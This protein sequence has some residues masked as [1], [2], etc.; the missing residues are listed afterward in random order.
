MR[1]IEVEQVG[2]YPRSRGGG[3]RDCR[4]FFQRVRRV[5]VPPDQLHSIVLVPHLNR[6]AKSGGGLE[7]D[8]S[9]L[10]PLKEDEN[11]VRRRG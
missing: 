8:L 7:G 10:V 9:N 11:I 5:D 2:S 1:F 3:G 6:K 4:E